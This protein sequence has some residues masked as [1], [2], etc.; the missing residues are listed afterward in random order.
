MIS[1]EKLIEKKSRLTDTQ[2]Y[3]C[4][5]NGNSQGSVI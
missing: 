1:I 2:I 4:W 5:K 3:V